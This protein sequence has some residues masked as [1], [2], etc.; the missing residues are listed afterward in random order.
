MSALAQA[1][2]TSRH[3]YARIWRHLR[4][5]HRDKRLTLALERLSE[6]QT[7]A[8]VGAAWGISGSALCRALLAYAP[9]EWR[10]AL[11]ARALLRY[12]QASDQFTADPGNSTARGR[13][14]A[15]R[16]HLEYALQK[17]VDASAVT[18]RLPSV[19]GD[20]PACSRSS[21]CGKIGQAAHCYRCGWEGEAKRYLLDQLQAPS[22][23]R[24]V[25]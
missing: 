6:G 10:R 25:L 20:C 12:E 8:Q 15:A 13:V 4:Q 23:E 22:G 21:A 14:W 5:D 16:W 2:T 24:V 1:G 17:L 3:D 19:S 7:L 11:V 9:L 18:V